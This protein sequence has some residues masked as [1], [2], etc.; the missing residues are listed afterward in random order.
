[1][2]KKPNRSWLAG[3]LAVLSVVGLA[4]CSSSWTIDLSQADQLTAPLVK[5]TQLYTDWTVVKPG[6]D[7]KQV[8][9]ETD[10]NEE[11]LD[12]V[13]IDPEQAEITLHVQE[14]E[15]LTVSDWQTKL[16]ASVVINGSYFD[17]DY[18]LVTRTIT[19]TGSAGPLLSGETGFFYQLDR[20]EIAAQPRQDRAY[21]VMQSYPLL[22]ANG[23]PA[24]TK[25]TDDSAQRTVVATNEAGMIYFIVAEY[26]VF[27][28]QEFSEALANLEGPE[29]KTAL[30]LDG[31]SSTGL[32]ISSPN[33][34]Y[35]DDSFVVPSVVAIQ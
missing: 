6:I 10:T 16:K 17:E 13:R 2:F 1:M 7:F 31:G 4:G 8:L 21:Q 3:G 12:I 11:L 20:W 5:P 14:G 15:P 25:S 28:L 19:A 26:G 35:S 27:T 22:V 29:L 32:V 34:E 9:V 24:V 30:N 23:E 33:L 18:N